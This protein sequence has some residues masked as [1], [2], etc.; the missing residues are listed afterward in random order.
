MKIFKY[1]LF[2]LM[3]GLVSCEPDGDTVFDQV[4]DA[5]TFGGVLR[6]VQ[7][8]SGNFNAFDP[9][10]EFSV[11][12]EEQ[13][14]QNG[15]LLESVDVYVKFNDF[16][17]DGVNLTTQEMLLETIPASAFTDGPNGLPRTTYSVTLGEVSSALGI[18]A[19]EY[20]GGDR[21]TI[22]FAL[23]LTDGR[24]FSAA[25]TSGP[26]SGG[27]YF[28][29]PFTYAANLV[30]PSE[31]NVPFTWVATDFFFQGSPVGVGPQ[32]GSDKLVRAANS[33]TSYTFESGFFDFG[34][35]C[36]VYSAANPGCGDGA[37]GSLKLSDVCGKLTY[38]GADQFG[39]AWEITNVMVDGNKLT[40]TW[41]SAYGERSTVTLTRTDG[42][43]WPDTLF[44]D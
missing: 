43:E 12:V 36:V 37:A 9:S 14:E 40:F 44:S 32:S 11:I 33:N 34:Y 42:M 22:R 15:D 28:K 38:T 16:T 23:N 8:V 4:R 10:S 3:I 17:E 2:F 7:V 18:D 19:D 39:D 35:Y 26:V 41:E 30:C 5:T 31:L 29:S 21:F 20:N 25:D 13:D 27:S 6:T 1:S 24:T